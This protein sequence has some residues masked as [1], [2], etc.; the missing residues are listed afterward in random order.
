[1]VAYAFHFLMIVLTVLQGI[2]KAFEIF[3]YLYIN[4]IARMYFPLVGKEAVLKALDGVCAL[5]LSFRISYPIS[6]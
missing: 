3:L 2:F 1:M 5:F 6:T 4:K